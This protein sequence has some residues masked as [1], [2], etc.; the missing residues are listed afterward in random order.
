MDPTRQ[1]KEMVSQR[2][3]RVSCRLCTA[4]TDNTTPAASSAYPPHNLTRDEPRL[5]M[6]GDYL[7]NFMG[8]SIFLVDKYEK[9]VYNNENL[10]FLF[11]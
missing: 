4:Q 10:I 7:D 1:L 3:L 5:S 6:W 11:R 9:Q 8:D 2:S